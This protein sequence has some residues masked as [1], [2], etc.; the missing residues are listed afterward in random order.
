MIDAGGSVIDT[1]NT[2]Q[3]AVE[4]VS[5]SSV[6]WFP[7]G[8]TLPFLALKGVLAVLGVILLI[9]DMN[10]RWNRVTSV[11]QQARYLTLLGFAVLLAGAS[12]EQVGEGMLLSY[13][14]LGAMIMSVAL[15]VTGVLSLRET[16]KNAQS[17]EKSVDR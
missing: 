6:A 13:R 16:H 5:Q 8:L 12:A 7:E 15:V 4:R 1:A 11:A 14:H 10:S 2:I 3:Q 9:L 17:V